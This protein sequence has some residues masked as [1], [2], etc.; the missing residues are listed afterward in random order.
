M[1]ENDI[2]IGRSIAEIAEGLP[3]KERK[4]PARQIY[5]QSQETRGTA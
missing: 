2:K 3:E 4:D 1:S 5:P